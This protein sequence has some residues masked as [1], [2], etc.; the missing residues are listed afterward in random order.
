MTVRVMKF[1][2][3][4]VGTVAS[5]TQVLSIILHE[6]QINQHL[7]VV[8]SALDGVTDMLLEAA[9]LARMD[10][11]R[12][13]RRIAATLRTRH[14]A[15]VDHLPLGP[16]ER[17]S[18]NADL[19]RLL[20]D[21]LDECQKI[22]ELP[23]ENDN[24][25]PA[26]SDR[27]IG[28]GERLAARIIAALL[29]QNDLR[30]VAI[31]G[32]ELIITD[33]T[34]GNARPSIDET[35]ERVEHHLR[36]LIER[37][38]VPVVTGFI[39]STSSGQPTTI[40]RGGSDLTAS[41]LAQILQADE[42]WIWSDV[43][44]IMT[45]DPREIKEAVNVPLLSYDEMAELSYFGARIL[46]PR[47]VEPLRQ[48]QIPLRVKNIFRPQHAGTLIQGKSTSATD[49]N[50]QIKAVSMVYGVG[51]SS[52]QRGPI[53]RI[54]EEIDKM[55]RNRSGD[56]ADV[57][58]VS[59]SARASFLCFVVPT[60]LGGIETAED[61]RASL[62]AHLQESTPNIWHTQLISIVTAIGSAFE[63]N[64]LLESRI[65]SQLT[66]LTILN[67]SRNPSGC[68]FSVIVSA[69]YGERTLQRIHDLII[70]SA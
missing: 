33:Q 2:G 34:Y 46:H 37:N 62:E 58:I 3:S 64:H 70:N 39:G 4:T 21:M 69:D 9:H 13:Y 42:L 59:Q 43:D 5:L 50:D 38:I 35:R 1:G 8:V 48:R 7:V 67:V 23:D 55:M 68:G 19:D 11:Q 6:R 24:L 36:P 51:L 53:N 20:F 32:T 44:G 14:L 15:L 10:N 30:G 56:H 63:H 28:V 40:G 65:L 22:T 47:M 41:L 66:N 31:D 49:P 29:R 27:V 57:L 52:Q 45:T 60:N 54:I 12:G 16:Q 18:L 26:S 25:S 17:T 61:V